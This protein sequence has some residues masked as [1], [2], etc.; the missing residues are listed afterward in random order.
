MKFFSLLAATLLLSITSSAQTGITETDI[1]NCGTAQINNQRLAEDPNLI[2]V[3]EAHNKLAIENEK[4]MTTNKTGP[5]LFTI[6]VV[7]HIIH[8]NGPENVSKSQIEAS[9]QNLNDDFQKLNLDVSQVVP[10]FTGIASDC[11]IQ[12]RLAHKDP[13]G[14]CTE[15]ITRTVSTLTYTAGENVKSLVN[16]NTTKYLN[17]WVVQT[18]SNGAG[19]YSYYPGY[20]PSQSAEGIVIRSAQLNNSVTHEV[21]HYLNLPHTWGSSNTP[22]LA[23]NCSS[24]DGVGD[25]PN[26][27]GNTGCNTSSITCGTL[28]NVQNYMDYA[29]CRRMFT[30]G[31]KSRMHTA[32]N[33]S[34]GSRNTLWTTSNL[35][36][37]GTNDPYGPVT[38]APVAEFS[39]NKQYIC[40]GDAVSF[41]DQSYNATPTAWNWTF[42]GGTPSSSSIANPSITY[43]NA[44]VYS[45][46]HQ[47]STS[48]GPGTITK[49]NIITVS[50]LTADYIGPIIDGFENQTQFGN[51]WRVENM[52]TGSQTWGNN[53]VASATGSRSVRVRNYFTS[54]I[55]EVDELISPSY[56]ISSASSK[57]LKFKV[58][59]AKKTST[60]TD[61]MLVYYSTNCGASWLLKLPL[62][63]A[64]L[65]T[66]PNHPT[67]FVPT[68]SEWIEKSLDLTSIGNATNVRFKFQFQSGGGND[69]YLDDINI[70]GG[71]VGID[72]E[73]YS[74]ASFSVY[75]NPTNAGA[76]I[77]FNLLSDVQNLTIVVKN[78][79]GQTVT[80]IIN[81]ET[82]NSGKY[83]LNID[84]QRQL[85]S[86]IYFIEFNADNN[87][88]TQKLII[89]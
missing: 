67:L 86:G 36:A 73:F 88:K 81:G 18:L 61:R 55:N 19:G 78:A 79:L 83:T 45:V 64:N 60:D 39:Y 48:T 7:Y 10:S 47:P 75:P 42:T 25:T 37:T 57:T 24:D 15:G 4:K 31:Q 49:T 54:N 44:G 56:D 16:W 22:A 52:E 87:V 20:A 50:S 38:C 58:A 30:N 2:K 70:G 13:N 9:M 14:N 17:I 74:V 62:T 76:K 65:V 33:N 8:N 51:D 3:F 53:N 69:V 1:L 68:S 32:L 11:Q 66:A 89:Q 43:N 21:G 71:A 77:S 34:W 40:E 82:F 85:S 5:I 12:F 26:T 28:D 6:P 72:N 46:T 41:T 35:N 80:N 59:F 63:T 27:I 23:G 29:P 84:E